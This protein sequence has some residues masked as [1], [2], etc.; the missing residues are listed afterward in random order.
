MNAS[1]GINR[2]RAYSSVIATSVKSPFQSG[3]QN[4][5]TSSGGVRSTR[6]NS[7]SDPDAAGGSDDSAGVVG[8]SDARGVDAGAG[9]CGG[10]PMTTGVRVRTGEHAIMKA[11]PRTAEAVTFP[12]CGLCQSRAYSASGCDQ[13]GFRRVFRDKLLAEARDDALH[14]R[15]NERLVTGVLA[16]RGSQRLRRAQ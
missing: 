13:F 5:G 2:A 12:T 4:D 1:A 11:V 14:E 3:V 8:A 6:A 9:R 10:S 7:W 16:A 15:R